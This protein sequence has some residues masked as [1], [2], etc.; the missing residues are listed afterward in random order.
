MLYIT[1]I[2][3]Y[4]PSLAGTS[5]LIIAAGLLWYIRFCA[6]QEYWCYNSRHIIFTGKRRRFVRPVS[7]GFTDRRIVSVK[8]FRRRKKRNLF[9]RGWRILRDIRHETTS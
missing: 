3:F 2:F 5:L 9:P 1:Q 7:T 8:N 6:Q 4:A